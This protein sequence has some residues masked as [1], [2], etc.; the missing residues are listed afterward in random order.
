MAKQCQAQIDEQG[1]LYLPKA[2]R[3]ALGIEGKS[4]NVELTVDVNKVFDNE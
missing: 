3:Q 1:R 2:T 4:A